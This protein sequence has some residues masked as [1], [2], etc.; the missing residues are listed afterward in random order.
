M[1][2]LQSLFRNFSGASHP[3]FADCVAI[4]LHCQNDVD[5]D[6]SKVAKAALALAGQVI[7]KPQEVRHKQTH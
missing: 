2:F 4:L 3:H 6:V 7:A 5:T 1:L